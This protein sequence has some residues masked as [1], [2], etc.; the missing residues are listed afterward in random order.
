M[1][2]EL[3]H[4]GATLPYVSVIVVVQQLMPSMGAAQGGESVALARLADKLSDHSWVAAFEK[5]RT[6]VLLQST[7]ASTDWVVFVKRDACTCA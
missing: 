6:A 3:F 4:M 2:A 5:A 7:Y 1:V